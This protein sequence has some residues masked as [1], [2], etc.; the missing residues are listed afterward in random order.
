MTND[1]GTSSMFNVYQDMTAE[2]AV[3]PGAKQRGMNGVNYCLMGLGGEVGE[4]Q[5]KFK[6]VMR[7]DRELDTTTKIEL[8]LEAGDVL[9]YLAR[10]CDEL[11]YELHEVA[12]MNI[13]KLWARKRKQTLQGE[14]DHR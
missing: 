2:T 14:G 9:W 13:D 6:K 5:N 8:A 4:L 7:G 11:G 12:Q 1:L 3:Y 10:L